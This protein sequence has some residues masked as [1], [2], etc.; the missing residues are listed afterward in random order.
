LIGRAAVGAISI[1]ATAS[2]AEI[3]MPSI[4]V[5]AR[6]RDAALVQSRCDVPQALCAGRPWLADRRRFGRPARSDLP[7]GG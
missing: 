2:V 3:E 4:A 5:A 1:F 6:G 7:A